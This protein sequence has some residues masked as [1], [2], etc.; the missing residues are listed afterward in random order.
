MVSSKRDYIFDV[1]K[2]YIP[3]KL[4]VDR[5]SFDAEIIEEN[6]YGMLFVVDLGSP[7]E[8]GVNNKHDKKFGVQFKKM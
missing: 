2:F 5:I 6:S 7:F 8:I 1:E 3:Q 4:I